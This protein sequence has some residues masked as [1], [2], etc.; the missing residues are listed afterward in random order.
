MRRQAA[1]EQH[2]GDQ[3]QPHAQ[4]AGIEL[5][6]GSVEMMGQERRMFGVTGRGVC[7]AHEMFT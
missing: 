5:L 6:L 2:L 7:F 3:E 4:F 1:E